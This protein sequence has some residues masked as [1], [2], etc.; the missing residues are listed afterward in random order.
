VIKSINL[1]MVGLGRGEIHVEGFGGET[2]RKNP[3]GRPGRRWEDIIKIDIRK[4][5]VGVWSGL[6]C[7]RIVIGSGKLRMLQ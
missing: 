1:R 5:Y 4:L 3:L 2:E 6:S 7:V